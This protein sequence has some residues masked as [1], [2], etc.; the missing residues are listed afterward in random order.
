MVQKTLLLRI[1]LNDLDRP[2]QQIAAH[3]Y[4]PQLLPLCQRGVQKLRH[5]QRRAVIDP[6]SAFDNLNR[7]LRRPE[8][9]A[10]LCAIIHIGSS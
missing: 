2:E 4:V 10:V 7:F 3:L 8:F 1:L 6:V 5:A 9:G